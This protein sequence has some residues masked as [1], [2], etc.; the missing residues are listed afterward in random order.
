MPLTDGTGPQAP[1]FEGAERLNAVT[2]PKWL[3]AAWAQITQLFNWQA[4]N[5]DTRIGALPLGFGPRYTAGD[6]LMG[7]DLLRARIADLLRSQVL[8]DRVIRIGVISDGTLGAAGKPDFPAGRV[9]INPS[10]PGGPF[11]AKPGAGAEGKAMMEILFDIVPDAQ[12]VFTGLDMAFRGR[13]VASTA[14]D[15][16]PDGMALHLIGADQPTSS[17]ESGSCSA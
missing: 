3:E 15:C 14:E 13:M 5:K 8:E 1:G 4:V 6:A 7:T 11:S 10:F 16:S 2:G 12:V 17:E 9:T